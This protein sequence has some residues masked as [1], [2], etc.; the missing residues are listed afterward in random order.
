MELTLDELARRSGMTGRNIRQ[1]Q[2]YGLLPPPERRGRV[3]I[4]TDDHLAR[5]NRIKELRA[6]GF[7]LDLIRR[8]LETPAADVEADVRHL[9]A[10]ALAPF[11]G[12]ERT[13]L[14]REEL[15][16][17]L[18]DDVVGPLQDA[19]LVEPAGDGYLVDGAVLALLEA[20]AEGGVRPAV[21]ATTLAKAQD[22]QRAIA[23]LLLD[24]LRDELWKPFLDAG[25]PTGKWREL[26][27]TIDRL[28]DLG[29]SAHSYL[30][31]RALDEVLTGLLVEEAG[32]L[33]NQLPG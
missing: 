22:H 16:A 10:G 11:A 30:F 9:A 24:T 1:W 5:I 13:R 21:L 17:K 31:Q 20:A 12:G 14:S 4:Y 32:R 26:A 33:R 8:V 25:M 7:P 2:T 27:D 29:T 28:R 3:G 19:D 6:Q 18:G 15:E 23:A